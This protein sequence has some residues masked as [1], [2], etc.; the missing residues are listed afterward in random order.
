MQDRNRRG[1]HL[2]HCAF[3]RKRDRL[4]VKTAESMCSLLQMHSANGRQE[5]VPIDKQSSYLLGRAAD[6]VDIPL[7]EPSC[8]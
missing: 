4:I 7:E 5:T 1:L 6:S 8:R 2:H 3:A